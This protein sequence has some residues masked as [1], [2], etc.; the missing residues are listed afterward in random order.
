MKAIEMAKAY[1][2]KGFEDRIYALWKE[3][4]VFKPENTAKG[5]AETAGKDPYVI[6]IP[7]PNVT[8]ILHVGHGLGISI[9]DIIIRYHRMSGEV[10]LWVPGTDRAPERRECISRN[11]R[12]PRDRRMARQV[13]RSFV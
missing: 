10:T 1:D 11:R 12:P 5:K 2:P 3:A 6:V 9:M 7:P 8:G 4:G 13:R